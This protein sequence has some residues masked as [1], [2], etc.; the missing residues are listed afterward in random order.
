[1]PRYVADLGE[2][3]WAAFILDGASPTLTEM[4][5]SSINTS[6]VL[7]L[8]LAAPT[9]NGGSFEV[10]S[11]EVISSLAGNAVQTY[12]A[13]SPSGPVR[14]LSPVF[15]GTE[16]G[17]SSEDN[18]RHVLWA[19]KSFTNIDHGV[20]ASGDYGYRYTD[21]AG[22]INGNTIATDC[23][24]IDLNGRRSISNTDYKVNVIS[25]SI[26]T[27]DNYPLTVYD[28]A[29]AHV[30]GNVMSGAAEGSGIQVVSSSGAAGVVTQDINKANKI[31]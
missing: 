25:N 28:A 8:D 30:E 23:T 29:Y 4:S 31:S 11:D 6:S 21:S 12:G 10:G 13:G 26:I 18:G 19:Q 2:N 27:G 14:F 20:V 22:T 1:M 15:T 17:C 9:F 3:R 5:F 16:N 24:G 7:V